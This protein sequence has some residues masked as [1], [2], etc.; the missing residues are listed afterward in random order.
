LAY[1]LGQVSFQGD[2]DD[3]R[4]L[5]VFSLRSLHEPLPKLRLDREAQCFFRSCHSLKSLSLDLKDL[6]YTCRGNLS[7]T[8]LE[9]SWYLLKSADKSIL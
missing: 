2:S 1:R 5:P 7:S 3:S 6:S 9:K 8:L 4:H